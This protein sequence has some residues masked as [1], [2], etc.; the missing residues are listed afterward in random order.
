MSPASPIPSQRPRSRRARRGRSD[1]PPRASRSRVSTASRPP[2]GDRPATPQQ[3][4]G[5][6]LGLPAADRPAAARQPVRVD[7]DVADLAAVAGGPGQR[8]AVDDEAA[9]DTDRAPDRAATSSSRGPRPTM[10]GEGREVGLVGERD[11]HVRARERSASRL[12]ER[13]V[14]PAE[15][16]RHRDHAV[17]ATDDADDGDPDPDDGLV[18]RRPDR[19]APAASRARAAA[20]SATL[21]RPRGRSIRT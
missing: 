14:A 9:T 19:G 12:A 20:M 6:D 16:R 13:L 1:R 4:H 17:A 3:R 11:R 2:S 10:L 21:E 7:R 15:V 8:P 5:A 18:G